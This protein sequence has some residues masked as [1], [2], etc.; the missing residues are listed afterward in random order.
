MERRRRPT[1]A[2]VARMAG[3]D[4]S[5]VSRVLRNDPRG[6]ASAETAERIRAAAGEIGYRAN[7]AARGL[8]SART[9]TLGL[10]LPGFSSPVYASIAHGVEERAGEQ[11]YGLVLGTHAA[12]D[13]HETITGMLMHGRV[14][15]LLVSSGRIEDRALRRLVEQ[16]PQSVVL[17]NRQV[18]GVA[19]SVVLRDADASAVAVAHLAE[20][21]HRRIC[22]IF[23]PRSLDTMVRRRRG[24]LAEATRR[25][26]EASVV[27]MAERDHRAGADGVVQALK[28]GTRPTALVAGTFPMGV[29]VLAGLHEAGVDVPGRISVVALHD[30]GLAD[31]LV[32][33]L[34]TVAM[35][36]ERLGAEAV[37]LA[38][39]LVDGAD[40]RRVVVPDPP[41]LVRRESTAS[42]I[43]ND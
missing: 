4:A 41:R 39:A 33:R 10:L 9:M 38:I 5:L 6:F 34:T 42:L 13:P 8:R 11:G 22:G 24:F 12:G 2:D 25:G 18:R 30:D 43:S 26:V 1:L 37:D 17:V 21:G 20:L 23:G 14:D 28:G 40:P 32:P 19:A 3:V 15:G 16:A 7:A 36:A 35:A 29:G 27:E 31:Y